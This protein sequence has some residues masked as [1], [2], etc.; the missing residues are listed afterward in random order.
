MLKRV[1]I[2]GVAA[3]LT[4][5]GLA[6]AQDKAPEPKPEA[7]PAEQAAKPEAAAEEKVP[8]LKVGDK[9]P[10]LEVEKFLKGSPVTKFE[11]GKVYVVEFWA[12]WCPPCKESIPHLTELQKKYADK[13][14]T[15]IGVDVSEDRRG[16]YTD[17]T[18]GMVSKF[19]EDFGDKMVYTVAFDGASKKM[20]KAYM[21][22]SHSQGIPTAFI[23]D[24]KGLVAYIGHPM[25]MES[26]LESVVAGTHDIKKLTEEYKG[27][28]R[29]Q[30]LMGKL[31][32]ALQ[33]ENEDE[34]Y[35]VAK[36]LMDIPGKGDPQA[37]FAVAW[38]CS[39]EQSPIKKKD[40]DMALK[41]AERVNEATEGKEP[42]VLGTLAQIQ[43]QKGDKDKAVETIGKAIEIAG[44]NEQYAPM[45]DQLK[46]KQEE[47]KG[48]K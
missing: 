39:S 19:V 6:L 40:L 14:L 41:A 42:A 17:E 2:T 5:C 32:E 48:G 11:D 8:T 43:F 38:L 47:Y 36:Q 25:Q 13:G 9:A 28:L 34:F 3:V 31:E 7:K 30:E 10:V 33:G 45:V 24:Q 46:K 21:E 1:A 15:I 37:L 29:A 16:P 27:T 22:A 35:K 20:D 44:K 12:T 18:A 4:M 23:V 26:T